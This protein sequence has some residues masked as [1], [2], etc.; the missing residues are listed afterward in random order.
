M[1]LSCI[2]AAILGLMSAS[3]QADFVGIYADANAMW[4]K[5]DSTTTANDNTDSKVNGFYSVAFEHPIP[6][7]PNVK[8]RYSKFDTDSSNSSSNGLSVETLDALGYYQ[9]LDNIISIDVGAGVKQ[10]NSD[11][12]SNVSQ[13]GATTRITKKYDNTIPAVYA[14]AGGKLPFTGLSAKAEV[15][16][17]KS[18]D[19]DFNDSNA[20]VKLNLIENIALDVGAKVGYRNM[21]INIDNNDNLKDVKFRG[22]YAGLEMHF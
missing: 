14:S 3:A 12:T 5:N 9:I 22:P 15:M 13:Q 19:A 10:V 7:I 4:S 1:T 18:S 6:F 20:E 17:G 8:V 2:S 16:V 21:V 11:L